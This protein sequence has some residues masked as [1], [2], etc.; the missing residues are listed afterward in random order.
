M[1][2]IELIST[3]VSLSTIRAQLKLPEGDGQALDPEDG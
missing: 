1:S 3:G 2:A